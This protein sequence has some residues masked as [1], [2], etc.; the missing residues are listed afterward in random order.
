MTNDRPFVAWLEAIHQEKKCGLATV[1]QEEKE[2]T[3]QPLRVFMDGSGELVHSLENQ[4][5]AY[6]ISKQI[7]EKLAM[8]H[9]SAAT[10]EVTLE[11]NEPIIVFVDVFVPQAKVMIFGA[12]HDAIPVAKYSVS[13]GYETTV[14]DAR[15]GFNT[16]ALFPNTKRIIAH[17]ESY[18]EN[19]TITENTYV[20]V[21]NHHIEKDRKTLEFVLP[22][23]AAYVGVLGPRSRRERMMNQLRDEGVVFSEQALRKMYNPVGLDIGADTPEEIAMSILSEIIAVRK[24]HQAGFLHDSQ[25]IHKRA[26]RYDAK[27]LHYEA[28]HRVQI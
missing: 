21:M 13:L 26:S 3:Y 8:T 10:V 28:V 23:N 6:M 4:D 18:A 24:G 11:G 20:I 1:L 17:P 25:S 12:G 15:E 5:F 22:S 27:I 19:V 9:P 16:E 7:Q 14:V 2:G